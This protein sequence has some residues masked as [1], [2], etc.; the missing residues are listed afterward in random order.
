[1]PDL[2]QGVA[3]YARAQAQARR[4]AVQPAAGTFDV[5]VW[6]S[7]SAHVER[8]SYEGRAEYRRCY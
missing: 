5:M 6:L 1:L 3:A 4:Q 7:V 2:R 8:S